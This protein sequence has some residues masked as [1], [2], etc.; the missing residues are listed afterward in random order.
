[1][2]KSPNKFGRILDEDGAFKAF[3]PLPD[4]QDGRP[5]PSNAPGAK[6]LEGVEQFLDPG[7]MTYKYSRMT[8][9]DGG[10]GTSLCMANPI[11]GRWACD[12]MDKLAKIVE[13]ESHYVEPCDLPPTERNWLLVNI[14]EDQRFIGTTTVYNTTIECLG[15]GNGGWNPLIYENGGILNLA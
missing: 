5:A 14:T 10:E 1:V 7:Q 15:S 8:V 12:V 11:M 9:T 13:I 6:R 3:G 4:G 2:G